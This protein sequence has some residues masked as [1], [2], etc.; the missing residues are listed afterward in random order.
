MATKIHTYVSQEPLVRPNAFI[1]EGDNG[2]V[3]VDTTLTMSDS[4]A[5]K[6]IA[7]G[8]LERWMPIYSSQPVRT[9]SILNLGSY[10]QDWIVRMLCRQI[11]A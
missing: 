8:R 9:G 10:T 7:D 1:V 6:Q 4:K 2:L 5:L 11:R 3:I